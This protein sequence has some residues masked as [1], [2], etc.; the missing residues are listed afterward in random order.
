MV[1][2]GVA[3]SLLGLVLVRR[4]VEVRR[5][6]PQ[7][8]VAGFIIAV[9]G[10]IYAVLLAFMVVVQWEQYSSA[11]ST[12][13]TEAVTLGNLYRDAAAFGTQGR[14][15]ARAVVAYSKEVVQKEYPS[16]SSHQEEDPHI[17]HY[18]NAMWKGVRS[19]P[20]SDPNEQAFVRQ[21]VADVSGAAEAR[22]T[23]IE[24]SS[25]LL[26][27]PMWVVLLVGGALTVGFTY[28]FGLERFAIQ[29][30]MVST[31]AVIISLS[32]FVILV[33]DL[34][35][36]GDIA[37]QPSALKAEINEFCS[38]NFVDPNLGSNCKGG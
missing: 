25:S 30:A 18:L 27:T 15:L 22:R 20:A 5:L 38:Y 2:L 21:A 11:S 1:L 16:V 23:R 13:A 19:L 31:L 36:T 24:D 10:V 28:F 8:D 37:V 7:H 12:A 6:Q 26:P 17:D 35:F 14:P 34:P 4:S 33:L 32:L 29:A 3:A 9:V